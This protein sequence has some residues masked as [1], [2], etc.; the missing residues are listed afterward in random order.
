MNDMVNKLKYFLIEE[1]GQDMVEYSLLLLLIGTVVLIYITGMGTSLL[2]LLQ[3]IGDRLDS[4]NR[5]TP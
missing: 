5:S 3:Q 4:V 2:T 1:R